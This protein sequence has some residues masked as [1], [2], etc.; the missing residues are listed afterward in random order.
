MLISFVDFVFFFY[1]FV[2]LYMT[3]LFLLIYARNKNEMFHYPKG[4]IEPVSIILPCYNAGQRVGD[5]IEALE[6]L[7]YP[8]NMF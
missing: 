7:D 3:S 4:K 1:M 8:K 6:N 2:G 5:T